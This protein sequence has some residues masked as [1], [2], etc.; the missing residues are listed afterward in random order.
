MV[1]LNWSRI[2]L[3]VR[4]RP[5]NLPETIASMKK[6]FARFFDQPA[7][8]AFVEDW[9]GRK[10]SRERRQGQSYAILAWPAVFL[11]GLG[12]FGLAAFE[13]EQRRREVGV[14]KVLGAW[15]GSIVTLFWKR[16]VRLVLAA[17]L[18]AW[19]AG[20]WLM[21]DWLSQFAYRID[22]SLTPFALAGSATGALF[23]AVVGSLA[24]RIGR[25]DPAETLR[26]E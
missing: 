3:G 23:L 14:R 6:T 25:V 10:Y 18:V 15:V 5:E 26:S 19:P 9:Y 4:V 22:L 20:Y 7:D 24:M 1:L 8:F 17:N 11:A 12:V 16:D 13:T 2:A 21:N